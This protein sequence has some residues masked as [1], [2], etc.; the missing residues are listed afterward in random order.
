M[1]SNPEIRETIF[2]RTLPRTIKGVRRSGRRVESSEDCE[3]QFPINYLPSRFNMLVHILSGLLYVL[4]LPNVRSSPGVTVWSATLRRLSK[5]CARLS[6]PFFC[7][8]TSQLRRWSVFPPTLRI[9]LRCSLANGINY[10]TK[11]DAKKSPLA[12][13]IRTWSLVVGTFELHALG[14][15]TSGIYFSFRFDKNTVK[16]CSFYWSIPL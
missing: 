7:V 8:L 9:S 14:L 12:P 5:R 6:S 4:S 13:G 15:G 16:S 1:P 2:A 11:P 10:S 3:R